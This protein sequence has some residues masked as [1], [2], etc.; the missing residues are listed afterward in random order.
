MKKRTAL[1]APTFPSKLPRRLIFPNRTR[2]AVGFP[3]NIRKC[4]AVPGSGA[5]TAETQRLCTQC[6][7][8]AFRQPTPVLPKPSKGKAGYDGHR[9]T[10]KCAEKSS[11]NARESKEVAARTSMTVDRQRRST[12]LSW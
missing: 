11:S 9:A 12:L 1:S 4:F 2:I 5:S 3:P 10:E 6:Y 8:Q 7:T